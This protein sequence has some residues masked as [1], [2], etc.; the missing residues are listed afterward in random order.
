MPVTEAPYDEQGNLIHYPKTRYTYANGVRTE[1]PYDWRLNEPFTATLKVTGFERGRSAARFF[2]A[3]Q[4][5]HEFPMFLKDLDQMLMTA[6]FTR[7]TVTG[8]WDVA[9]RGENYGLRYL[10]PADDADQA[11]LV[12]R[13]ELVHALA[14]IDIP[15]MPLPADGV[16]TLSAESLADALVEALTSGKKVQV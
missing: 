12:T 16:I 6:D 13:A 2:W 15:E 4:D 5:G 11:L 10:G 3:D 8:R 7:G 14:Q 1:I 9:K